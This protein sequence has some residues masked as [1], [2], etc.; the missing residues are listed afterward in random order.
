MTFHPGA[1]ACQEAGYRP[2]Q[3]CRPETAPDLGAWRGASNT[4]LRALELIESGALDTGDVED[5]A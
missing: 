2:C 3:R 4:A 1:A 5:L